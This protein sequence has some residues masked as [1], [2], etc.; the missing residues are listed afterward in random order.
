VAV[1][2]VLGVVRGRGRRGHRGAARL[3]DE[4][5][6]PP[7]QLLDPLPSRR[8]D[9]DR[10]R[11]GP[12]EHRRHGPALGDVDLVERHQPLP[13]G[14]HRAEGGELGADGREGLPSSLDPRRRID[15]VDEQPGALEVAEEV[16]P[17]PGAAVG[18]LDEPGNVGEDQGAPALELGW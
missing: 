8:G 9:R 12:G 1:D 5:G 6:D 11:L 2:A 16:D 17:Q 3:G 10:R 13:L 14:E 4:D 15:D 18:A 7:E